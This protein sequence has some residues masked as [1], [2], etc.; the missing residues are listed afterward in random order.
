MKPQNAKHVLLD[1]F[2][3]ADLKTDAMQ[4]VEAW[5]IF[6][7]FARLPVRKNDIAYSDFFTWECAAPTD[8]DL[9]EGLGI[10]GGFCR[11]MGSINEGEVIERI[12]ELFCIF[13]YKL[14]EELQEFSEPDYIASADLDEFIYAVEKSKSFGLLIKH[15]AFRC[16][17]S[18]A[19]L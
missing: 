14:D 8:E 3:Q 2:A 1:M 15:Q 19:P 6:K 17:I 7:E 4:L 18:Q 11:S 13:E 9:E 5:P 12:E 10:Q 16:G